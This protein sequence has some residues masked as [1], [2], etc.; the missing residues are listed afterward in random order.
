MPFDDD[1]DSGFVFIWRSIRASWVWPKY[2]AYWMDLIMM[3]AWKPTVI[4]IDGEVVNIG[5]GQLLTSARLLAARWKLSPS[6]VHGFLRRLKED[7]MI[8]TDSPILSKHSCRTHL[9]TRLTIVNYAKY[10]PVTAAAQAVQNGNPNT[11]YGSED[12]RAK[13]KS[14]I[15]DVTGEQ[16]AEPPTRPP[17]SLPSEAILLLQELEAAGGQAPDFWPD[18]QLRE[19]VALGARLGWPAVSAG[20][21]AILG[22]ELSLTGR[23]PASLRYYVKA[24]SGVSAS[25][26]AP[27]VAAI[28]NAYPDHSTVG[29]EASL[30]FFASLDEL[31]RKP[32]LRA[33]KLGEFAAL[34][35]QLKKV[36][37]GG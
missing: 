34:V 5:C 25:L 8:C 20:A 12:L 4:D 7:G 29:S 17:A 30:K 27:S 15:I 3:A 28:A 36:R 26:P 9:R 31:S 16:E 23:P 24:L 37:E 35:G 10:Q 21:L 33:G 1:R 18:G 32:G 11:L 6:T 22:R 14:D 13:R 19:L 2:V